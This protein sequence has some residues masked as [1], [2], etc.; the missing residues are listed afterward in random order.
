[1]NTSLTPYAIFG[2][3][4]L[5]VLGIFAPKFAGALLVLIVVALAIANH[6]TQT[7]ISGG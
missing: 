6:N 1:M 3:A 5:I 2:L 4:M 7:I